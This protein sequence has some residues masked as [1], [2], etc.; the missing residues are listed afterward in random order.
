MTEC[1]INPDSYSRPKP[2]FWLAAATLI[3]VFLILVIFNSF[4]CD[5][6]FITFRFSK[7]L[8]AGLGPIYNTGERVEGYTN[9]FWMILM[10]LVIKFGGA[11]TLWSLIIAA[12]FSVATLILF[13]RHIFRDSRRNEI[14]GFIFVL[15]L[16]LSSPFIAWSSGGLETAAFGFFIFAGIVTYS[17][18]LKGGKH[19]GMILS[20]I[21]FSL[22][23]L[24][25]PEGVLAFCLAAGF[26]LAALIIKNTLP[27]QVLEF[28]LPFLILY[29]LY[30][31]WRFGY[32]G[33]LFPNTF[34]IKEPSSLLLPFG[35]KY[36]KSFLIGC[37]VWIP[38]I[39]AAFCGIKSRFRGLM[40]GDYFI[41]AFFIVFSLYVIYVG[42]DF[43]DLWRFIMPLLAPFFLMLYHLSLAETDNRFF[44]YKIIAAITAL[45]IFAGFN[46]NSIYRSQ[47]ISYDN[48]VD[49]IGV[50]RYYV[51]QWSSV[52]KLL[53][54]IGQPTDTIAISAAGIIPYYTDMYAIDMYGLE[55]ADLSKYGRLEQFARPGHRMT[56]SL[57]Y[58]YANKPHYMVAHPLVTE[59]QPRYFPYSR[60]Q[61]LYPAL[62]KDYTAIS[63]A[64]PDMPGYYFNFRV[65]NDIV[66]KINKEIKIYKV[67]YWSR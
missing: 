58:L 45:I 51:S 32:Y 49:S 27:R 18:S 28:I 60:A 43:M 2:I 36:Y 62:L 1:K 20:S 8:A 52:G 7:N 9:F 55:A 11:P 61:D 23:S 24:T 66:D 63:I 3:I 13:L 29:G 57:Q 41:A 26:L 42:G 53:S 16:A 14:I 5:D 22:A 37:P 12:C 47:S 64:L 38:F 25:R 31:V 48:N 46:L 56:I 30:F 15:F 39:L 65:R 34:Y 17:E 35:V 67:D 19:R 33:K 59:G 44:K 40:L 6:A 4:L 54:E 50:L 21:L 10:A